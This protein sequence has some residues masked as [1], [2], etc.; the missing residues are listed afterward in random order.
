MVRPL[1]RYLL[2]A[3]G[4]LFLY[5]GIYKLLYPG[6]AAMSLETLGV[7]RTVADL[8]ITG[9][10]VLELYLGIILLLKIDLRWG[11]GLSMG[12]MF[13]FTCYMWYL[14]TLANPPRCGCLGLTGLFESSKHDALF[15]VFR[16]VAILWALKLAYDYYVRSSKASA[17]ATPE[18]AMATHSSE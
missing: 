2:P 16:N 3:V 1:G 14:S 11:L 13:F 7:S 9:A 18:A 8:A 15:G 10:V 17:T 6:Q 12:M 5:S 4:L